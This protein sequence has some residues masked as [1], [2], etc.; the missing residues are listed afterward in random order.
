MCVTY[1]VYFELPICYKFVSVPM[2]TC[3]ITEWQTVIATGA[4]P[5]TSKRAT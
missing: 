4:H 2:S 3:F 1:H 5:G